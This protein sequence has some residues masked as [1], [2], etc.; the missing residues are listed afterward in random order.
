MPRERSAIERHASGATSSFITPAPRSRISQS[1]SGVYSRSCSMMPKRARNGELSSP[2]RVVAPTSVKCGRLIQMLR[3]IGPEP[4]TMWSVKSSIAEY[5]TSSMA[6]DMRWIS[7]IKSTS[8]GCRFERIAARSPVF[9]SA[10]PVVIRSSLCIS[11]AMMPARVVLP[12][13]GGP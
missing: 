13:P 8:C 4:T 10:G 12:S 6:V 1:S 5:S 2:R 9:S 7:S 11:C 3:A